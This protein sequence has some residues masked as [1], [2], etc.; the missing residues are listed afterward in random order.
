MQLAASAL[1]HRFSLQTCQ[2]L[3]MD[4]LTNADTTMKNQCLATRFCDNARRKKK[5]L[6]LFLPPPM[7]DRKFEN[8]ILKNKTKNNQQIST[9]KRNI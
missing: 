7:E 8:E 3:V 9:I 2:H 1:E 6:F 4:T 5:W